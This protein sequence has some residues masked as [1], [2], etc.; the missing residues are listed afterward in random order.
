[1]FSISHSDDRE[2]TQT[3]NQQILDAQK[4][5]L[6]LVR[7]YNSR[8]GQVTDTAYLDGLPRYIDLEQESE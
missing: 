5:R 8:A 1:M 4:R 7:E 6:A 3:L 2:A